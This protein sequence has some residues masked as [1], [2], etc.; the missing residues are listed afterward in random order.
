MGVSDVGVSDI[1]A[2]FIAS[3]GIAYRVKN[4]PGGVFSRS[5]TIL[6]HSLALLLLIC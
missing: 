1:L 5:Y 3:L 2:R 4:E 6:S